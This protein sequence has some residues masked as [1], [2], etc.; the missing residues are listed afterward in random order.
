MWKIHNEGQSR[1]WSTSSRL[2]IPCP[3]NRNRIC[4]L[5]FWGFFMAKVVSA[6]KGIGWE[7]GQTWWGSGVTSGG[8]QRI[9]SGIQ[10]RVREM[11]G[12]GLNPCINLSGPRNWVF[13]ELTDY[14]SR[15][16]STQQ[17]PEIGDLI[18]RKHERYQ[19]LL[20]L[21]FKTPILG[22]RTN[23]ASNGIIVT[24]G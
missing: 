8:S 9:I 14:R 4:F 23:E 24:M 6:H 10:T 19:K 22:I 3:Q 15:P 1:A 5:V 17:E 21:F 2:P 18:F 11:Q 12:N 7:K 20:G 16:G 13:I